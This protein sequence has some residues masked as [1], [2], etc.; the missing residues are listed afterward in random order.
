MHGRF[1]VRMSAFVVVLG[2]A[3]GGWAATAARAQDVTFRLDWKVYGTH[4]PF[5][6]AEK[7]GYYKAEGLNVK[8]LEGS[9]SGAVVKLMGAKGDTFAFASGSTTLTAVTRGIP[10]K[11]V[12]GIMQKSPL[13]VIYLKKNALRSPRDLIGKTVSTSGGGSGT[14][15]FSAFL[16]ANRIPSDQV[17]LASLGTGGRNRALLAEKV[18]GML[19]YTVTEIPTLEA[20]GHEVGSM[21]YADW[22]MNT[23]ANGII[24]NT[25]TEKDPE[26]I[27]KF[28]RAVT[29]GIEY[30]R[31]HQDEAAA[32][33]HERFPHKEMAILKKE[34]RWT[35]DLLVSESTK[36]KPLGWQAES[37]W[38]RTETVL[39]ENNLIKEMKSLSAY[40]TNRYIR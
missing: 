3:A 19:G 12:Y 30:A 22:G 33:M 40:F 4:A 16:K 14:A 24:V 18:V 35:L 21:L 17:T 10:V 9:G 37:D 7:K 38:R 39:K 27:V 36:G 8:I 34:L 31:D 6:I 28:L 32:Y 20:R 26:L 1:R 29:K 5:F 25:E 2:L 23:V 11:S 13:A 15:L